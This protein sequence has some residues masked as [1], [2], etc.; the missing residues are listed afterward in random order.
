MIAKMICAI[1]CIKAGVPYVVI[2]P[3]EDETKLSHILATA[4]VSVALAETDDATVFAKT[5]SLSVVRIERNATARSVEN[6][7]PEDRLVWL[8]P[9]SGST[10][11]PKLV[12]V[13][14]ATLQHY[15][16]L[17]TKF[18]TIKQTDVVGNFGE[19]WLDT[20]LVAPYVGASTRHFNLRLLGTAELDSWMRR[21]EVSAVQTYVAAFRA[22]AGASNDI[23]PKLQTVRVAGEL[24]TTADV[25]S[26]E[27]ITPQTATLTN[28]LGS[29]EC[30]FIA[31]HVH[32]HGDDVP[33][34]GLPVGHIV[35]G[36][37]VDIVDDLGAPL[38]NGSTGVVVIKARH[39]AT[40]YYN[41]AEKTEGVYWEDAN[42]MRAL[43]TGDLGVVSQHGELTLLGRADDQVTIRGY[44][45][46]YSE[47]EAVLAKAPGLETVAV[48]SHVSPTGIRYLSGH[49]EAAVPKSDEV[50]KAHMVASLPSYMVPNYYL[51]YDALPRTGT[52]KVLK[53]GLRDPAE[54]ARAKPAVDR[55]SW[56]PEICVLA[57]IWE[58]I[59]GHAAYDLDDDFFDVGGD[60]LQAMEMVLAVERERKARVG[61][62][63][64]V[65][66]GASL[67]QIDQY[68]RSDTS[69]VVTLRNDAVME[70]DVPLYLLPVE[71]SEFSPWLRICQD[72]PG[73][74]RIFGVHAR[75]PDQLQGLRPEAP[76]AFG[77]RAARNILDHAGHGD[78][79]VAG[80]SAGTHTALETARA[81]TRLGQPPRG[82][83]LLDPTLVAHE[84]YARSWKARRILSPLFKR[85]DLR[86]T[87]QRAGHI[88][89]GQPTDELPIADEAAFYAY[90]LH[91]SAVAP[92]L[93]FLSLEENPQRLEKEKAWRQCVDPTASVEVLSCNHQSIV[94]PPNAVRVAALMAEWI[95]GLNR[96]ENR[97]ETP[98]NV[99]NPLAVTA[100]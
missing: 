97:R 95:D 40:G 98:K 1:G 32:H 80:Y 43:N 100:A 66:R 38:P 65:L 87:L 37:T 88:L 91:P 92:V 59:L 31:Q 20:F 15:L 23:F 30:S 58:A 64:L 2:D 78:V 47:V 99:Q 84:P 29:T 67:R 53:R 73:K 13:D 19:M 51:H 5:R 25:A 62:E 63:N 4:D 94:R 48:T 10:G 72:M 41:N 17:Q 27:R 36:T 42:G 96:Q 54:V 39:L 14:R 75:S 83:I 55:S 68:V 70:S 24:V 86:M 45:V 56:T 61:Y 82:L 11:Q 34:G 79:F 89:F 8:E 26:F 6:P 44:S 77:E 90:R 9:T 22:L 69:S 60:S 7:V 28:Y 18:S 71:N 52:G 12:G 81:L 3:T 49:Y 93:M 33:H 57:R 46:R 21:N 35:P 16:D 76:E 50:L 74:R 85:A